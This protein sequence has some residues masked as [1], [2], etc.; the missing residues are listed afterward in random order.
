MEGAAFVEEAGAGGGVDGAVD[1]AA[2]EEGFVGCVY[3][4]GGGEGGD[5]RAD[6]GDFVVEG[7][8]GGEGGC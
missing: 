7:C 6:E 3:D 8:G 1:A 4:G 5:V 2:A